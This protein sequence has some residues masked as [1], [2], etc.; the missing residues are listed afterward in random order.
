VENQIAQKE[1]TQDGQGG[2]AQRKEKS[3]HLE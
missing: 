1:T 2:H 3:L